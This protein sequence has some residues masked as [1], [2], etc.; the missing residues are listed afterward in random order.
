MFSHLFFSVLCMVAVD[1][2][3]EHI[4]KVNKIDLEK[5]VDD[6]SG[7]YAC[8]G[9]EGSGRKYSGIAVITKKNQAY[10]IQWVIGS[11]STFTGIGIRQGNTFSA[12]WAMVDN[13]GLVR[14]VNTYRIE[15]GPKLVGHWATLPGNSLLQRETLTFLKGLESDQD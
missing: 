4:Q 13:K 2:K 6:I 1:R 8:K 9:V 3:D 14:G 12:G 10:A 15:P 7:Y 11:T 5:E